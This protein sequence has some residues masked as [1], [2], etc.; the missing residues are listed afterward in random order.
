MNLKKILSLLKFLNNK[1]MGYFQKNK[2]TT[3][4]LFIHEYTGIEK[5]ELNNR[6]HDFMTSTGVF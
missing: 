1:I 4:Q 3:N 6:I 5:Q 2:L